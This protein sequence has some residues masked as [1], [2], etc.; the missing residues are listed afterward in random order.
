M[1]MI[2][3]GNDAVNN[4]V[5]GDNVQNIENSRYK[6]REGGGNYLLI[7]SEYRKPSSC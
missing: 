3:T 5:G 2:S 1:V 4:V 7:N 6:A